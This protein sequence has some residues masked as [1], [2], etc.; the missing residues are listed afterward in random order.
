MARLIRLALRQ[1]KIRPSNWERPVVDIDRTNK[2]IFRFRETQL[3]NQI[4]NE[5]EDNN[6][7][8]YKLL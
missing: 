8:F 7:H 5:D 6:I 4:D 3:S 2:Y 1:G